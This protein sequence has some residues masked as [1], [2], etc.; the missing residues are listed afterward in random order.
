[1]VTPPTPSQGSSGKLILIL[2]AWGLAL[3]I[4]NMPNIDVFASYAIA[5][6]QT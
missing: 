5:W 2:S 1:M 3:L 4:S 6:F